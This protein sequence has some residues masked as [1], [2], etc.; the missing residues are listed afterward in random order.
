MAIRTALVQE[1]GQW[2]H[3]RRGAKE[4]VDKDDGSA[5]GSVTVLERERLVL[6]LLKELGYG[7]R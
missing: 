1:V 5:F 3:F 2:A 7:R 6:W 4:T